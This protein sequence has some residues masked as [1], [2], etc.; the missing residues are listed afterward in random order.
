[1]AMWRELLSRSAWLT[2]GSVVGR[3]APYAVL[4]ALGRQLD[5]VAFA[6]LSIA[7]AWASVAASLVTAALGAVTT[8]RLAADPGPGRRMLALRALGQGAAWSGLLTIA[9][10][11]LGAPVAVRAFGDHLDPAA[12]WP[13]LA[14]GLAWSLTLL[15]GALLNGLHAVR[16]SALVL[17][18]GGIGQA[19]GMGFGFVTGHSLGASLW[20]LALGSAASLALGLVLL[21]GA[22]PPAEPCALQKPRFRL[23]VAWGTLA[24]AAVTPVAFAAAALVTRHG[25]P[26][27]DLAQYQ[28][29]EQVHQLLLFAPGLIGQALLPLL[30]AHDRGSEAQRSLRPWVYRSAAAGLLAAT[31]IGWRPEWVL[32]ALGNPALTDLWATRWMLCN[33]SLA[34]A[35]S[36]LHNELMARRLYAPAALLS[37]SWAAVFLGLGSLFGGVAGMQAGRLVASLLLF[38]AVC[39]LTSRPFRSA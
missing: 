23:D 26:A 20:G 2:A 1:M 32:H 4:I 35:L 6:S 3:L 10:A 19:L 36:L 5:P 27:E 14:H 29:L 22:L 7:F 34:L 9:I 18:V 25:A 12:F 21:H 16:R 28:A 13:A 31:L 30:A 38:A 8:Q 39:A 11:A 17:G 37:L 33:A 24:N 15:V